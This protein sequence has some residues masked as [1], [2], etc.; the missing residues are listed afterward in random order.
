MKIIIVFI[1]AFTCMFLPQDLNHDLVPNGDFENFKKCPKREACFTNNIY[2]WFSPNKATPDLF[3]SCSK[4]KFASSTNSTA[5][6]CVP[7]SG[8]AFSG[9][10][11]Y[12]KKYPDYRE[13]ISVKLSE[14]LIRDS[15]YVLTLYVRISDYSLIAVDSIGVEFSKSRPKTRDKTAMK[16]PYHNIHKIYNTAND[17]LS[18]SKV[19]LRFKSVGGERYLT[20]GNFES[21]LQTKRSVHRNAIV[22]KGVSS[23]SYYKI[24]DD[25]YYGIDSVSLVKSSKIIVAKSRQ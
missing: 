19:S 16:G 3:A 15:V 21:D 8:S 6:N 12:S 1:F 10:L 18:W 13:Y 24:D 4:D 7:F 17:T 23:M 25:A 11:L 20:L 2:G 22:Q 9:I 5:F 14:S